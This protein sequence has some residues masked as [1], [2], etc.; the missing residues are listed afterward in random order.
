MITVRELLSDK[1]FSG[2][3][4]LAGE[5]GL[6]K[7]H[8]NTLCVIDTPDLSGWV[9]GNEFF[10]SSGYI[11]KEDPAKLLAIVETAAKNGAAALGIKTGRF[12]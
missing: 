9:L 10:I 6:D 2:F 4:V 8:I 5:D 7:R 12:T 11:F 1:S 3:V